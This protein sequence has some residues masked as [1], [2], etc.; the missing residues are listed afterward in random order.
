MKP[1]S[2]LLLA[3]TLAPSVSWALGIRV[4]DQHA[5][6]VARGNAF[7]ATA[8]NPS[9][10]YYNPAGITQLDGLQAVAGVYAVGFETK[11]NLDNGDSFTTTNDAWQL[12]PQTFLTYKPAGQPVAIGLGVYSPFGFSLDY[13]DNTA[14]RALAH[15]GSI[16]TITAAPVLALQVTR[17][18]SL[19]V[20][21]MATYG[22][23]ELERGV[24]APGDQFH[25]EGD[26]VGF[27]FN[28]GLLWVP[29]RM[30]R[31]GISYRSAYSIE[32][33]GDSRLQYD[34]F[35]V[36]TP[37]GPFP[38]PGVDQRQSARANFQ[39]PQVA[40]FGYA[41]TPTDDWNFEFN[42]DWTDW[43]NLNVVTLEQKSGNVLLPFNW[44][45]SFMYEFGV[46][47]KFSHGL[48]ASAGYMY[49]ENSVPNES[50]NP[51]VPDMDRHVFSVGLGQ[52]LSKFTWDVAY[53]YTYG[54]SRNIDQ[55]TAADGNYSFKSHAVS[56]SLG[57][58]F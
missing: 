50:F 54:P 28:A 49:T 1:L 58:K 16:Q 9:A 57:Y 44:R 4:S 17:S 56:V 23:A 7:A 42:L 38:V 2:T 10:L 39:F 12:V 52:R 30:H 13:P 25:F 5:E 46:T 41:F 33:D 34:G 26:G 18:L 27:G 37:F 22:K 21:A 36:P 19:A 11:V 40:V 47:K 29:H 51:S 20:G 6:A 14:F 3:I 55:G 32:F 8:D 48:R 35:E 31:F 45:S 43:N 15:K 24:L 53:Q